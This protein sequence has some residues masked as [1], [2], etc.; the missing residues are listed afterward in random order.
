MTT[1]DPFA[2]RCRYCG[3]RLKEDLPMPQ[4]PK[5][6]GHDHADER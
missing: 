5:P 4:C 3:T 1:C 6:E 2:G